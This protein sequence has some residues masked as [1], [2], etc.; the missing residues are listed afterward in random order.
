MK[1]ALSKAKA[2]IVVVPQALMKLSQ[3]LVDPYLSCL[4]VILYNWPVDSVVLAGK[5]HVP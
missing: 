5:T 1:G 3:T 2:S 4:A